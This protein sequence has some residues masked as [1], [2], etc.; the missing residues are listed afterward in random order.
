MLKGILQSELFFCNHIGMSE[1]DV[2]DIAAFTVRDEKGDGLREYLQDYAISDENTGIMRTYMVRDNYSSELV[3][4]FSLKAGLISLNEH[5]E[6]ISD[7]ETG[8]NATV[9][10]FDTL[11]GVELANFAVNDTYIRNHPALKGVGLVIYEQ[12]I[13]PLI[14]RASELIGAKIL[15]IFALPYKDLIARYVDYGFKRL[16]DPFEDELHKRLKPSYDQ[17]CIFMYQIL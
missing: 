16:D 17:S 7:N 12:F 5:E 13:L 15:Y 14:G 1:K 11:P 9:T 4:Y 6:E 8:S 10:M 3:G 2:E